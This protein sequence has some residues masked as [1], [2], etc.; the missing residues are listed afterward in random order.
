MFLHRLRYG[1]FSFILI[2][3]SVSASIIRQRSYLHL[4]HLVQSQEVTFTIWWQDPAHQ[5]PNCWF[6]IVTW[7][8][9]A[10]K[11]P[12]PTCYLNN[13]L[14][15]YYTALLHRIREGKTNNWSSKRFGVCTSKTDIAWCKVK[16]SVFSICHAIVSI[17][18]SASALYMDANCV[19]TFTIPRE[20]NHFH[21]KITSNLDIRRKARLDT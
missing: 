1:L 16:V 17:T 12:A 21:E 20:N 8:V 5:Q 18:I 11:E 19:I 9:L 7:G 13:T 6:V 15:R 14:R 4:N 3:E 10:H 2:G